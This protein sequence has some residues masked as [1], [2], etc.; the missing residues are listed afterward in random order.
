MAKKSRNIRKLLITVEGSIVSDGLILN[1][2]MSTYMF[3][4]K[5]YL[6]IS[7]FKESNYFILYLLVVSLKFL[8]LEEVQYAF[9]LLS[10]T[11]TEILSSI[12]SYTFYILVLILLVLDNY[13]RAVLLFRILEIVWLL[14]IRVRVYCML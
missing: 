7:I 12:I 8:F 13:K 9:T 11:L 6:T 1:C 14:S 2:S 4:K 5:D 10:T 3:A